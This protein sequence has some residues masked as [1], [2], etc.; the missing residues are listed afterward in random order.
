MEGAREG[1]KHGTPWL[2]PRLLRRIDMALAIAR[3][4]AP[5]YIR[6]EEIYDTV[7]TGLAIVESVAAAFGIV[8][9]SEGDPLRAAQLAFTLSGDADTIGAIACA[10][11][12]TWRGIDSI[13]MSSQRSLQTANPAYDFAG[14]AD[15]LTRLAL[16]R[17]G[18]L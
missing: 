11:A 12:G 8:H 14:I 1:E 13:P 3:S 2:A 5:E 9:M 4:D 15:G 7:G 18:V 10:I 17:A 16:K 6:L